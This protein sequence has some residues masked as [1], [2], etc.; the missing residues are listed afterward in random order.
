MME[1]DRRLSWKV[2]LARKIL[3]AKGGVISAEDI[4]AFILEY[5]ERCELGSIW[6]VEDLAAKARTDPDFLKKLL[7]DNG[8]A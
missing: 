5:N 1:D 7:G 8:T 6:A 4:E 3:E 2:E